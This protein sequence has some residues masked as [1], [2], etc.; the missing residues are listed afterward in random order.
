MQDVPPDKE[1]LRKLHQTIQKVTDD[2]DAMRFNTAIAAMMEFTNHLTPLAVRPKSVLETFVLLLS[3]FAPHLA[4][5]LWQALGHTDT[6]AY[7]P[8]PSL[9]SSADSRRT[10]S[11]CRCRS[12]AR[13]AAKSRCPPRS[14][15]AALEKTVLADERIQ[16]LI[17]GK[18]I[19]KVIVVPGKLVNIVAT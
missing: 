13:C 5:E 6:L 7:E 10:R 12:T 19:R 9:R 15:E 18:T 8:W 17:A 4:E 3:P 2:L 11:R 1:T 16:E 14:S